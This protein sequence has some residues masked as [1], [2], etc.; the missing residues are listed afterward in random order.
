MPI[1]GG[2]HTEILKESNHT[3]FPKNNLLDRPAFQTTTLK[4]DA[5]Q[6]ARNNGYRLS[7]ELSEY[8]A[9]I[10][11][12]SPD[13]NRHYTEYLMAPKAPLLS[14][15][16]SLVSS[17]HD[18]DS[19]FDLYGGRLSVVSGVND[20][21]SGRVS[22][23]GDSATTA[24]VSVAKM[25]ER[26]AGVDPESSKWIHRDKLAQI[27]GN[28]AADYLYDVGKSRWI[29]KDKLE[30]IEIEELQQA[31]VPLS[32]GKT[33]NS[34]GQNEDGQKPNHPSSDNSDEDGGVDVEF[35]DIRTLEEIAADDTP[36][37]SMN[38]RQFK[39]NPSYSRIPLASLSPH[40]IPQ[41]FIE[42][43]TPLP[44]T[45]VTPNGSDDGGTGL[46]HFGARKRSHSV[47][48]AFLL[49][50][51]E[52]SSSGNSITPT[53]GT[54]N[55]N[56]PK[57]R[58][59]TSPS[60]QRRSTASRNGSIGAKQRT[61]SNPQLSHRPGTSASH[62]TH[63]SGGTQSSSNKSPEGPPPWAVSSYKPDPSLPQDQQIIPT[64]A[65][66]MQ[67]EQWERDGACASI[68]DKDMRPLR[69]HCNGHTEKGNVDEQGVESKDEWPLKSS[70][71]LEPPAPQH[72]TEQSSGIDGG[73][74]LMPSVNGQPPVDPPPPISQQRTD[75]DKEKK[76]FCCCIIM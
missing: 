32:G 19:V 57:S 20:D 25:P 69:V 39:R 38:R 16:D 24:N 31:G 10:G 45:A 18:G 5:K 26:I 49:D 43:T 13:E 72:K 71:P 1:Y 12:H 53:P 74:S 11:R 23:L 42:R 56:N 14:K 67:Q 28:E 73:Y 70:S 4:S 30:M 47:G 34:S 61:R 76:K 41:Q 6:S 48:S 7:Q 3:V 35:H 62:A 54:G 60:Q 51:H 50:E 66:R 27:E 64:L 8:D 55:I 33:G 68:Y 58:N 59:V 17:N 52:N 37:Q 63:G 15:R 2:D 29:H 21:V 75:N 65:R 46:M 9:H 36:V 44:R 22:S 40:P